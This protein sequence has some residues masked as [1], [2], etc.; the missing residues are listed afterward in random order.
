M[1]KDTIQS[2]S[3]SRQMEDM[4]NAV[5]PGPTG[6]YRLSQGDDKGWPIKWSPVYDWIQTSTESIPWDERFSSERKAIPLIPEARV[7]V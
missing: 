1:L 7:L 4:L 5:P 6:V 3:E 2:E